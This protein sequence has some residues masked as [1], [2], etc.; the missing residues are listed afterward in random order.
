MNRRDLILLIYGWST[1][2]AMFIIGL[3]HGYCWWRQKKR[4]KPK[5]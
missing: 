4:N 5:P 1:P 3:W 2:A